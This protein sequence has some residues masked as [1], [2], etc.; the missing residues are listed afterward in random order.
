MHKNTIRYHRICAKFIT[1]RD[2]NL[3]Y[4]RWLTA[5]TKLAEQVLLDDDCQW[6]SDQF[7]ID[8]RSLIIGSYW[9]LTNYHSGQFS[10]EYQALSALGRVYSPGMMAGPEP[11]STEELVY[12]SLEERV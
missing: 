10:P 12:Q 8:L 11:E 2:S 4:N 5:I 9:Y 1:R 7:D 3:G 6:D